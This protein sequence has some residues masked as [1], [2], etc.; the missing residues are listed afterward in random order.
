M[1]RRH[2]NAAIG[3][4]K[5]YTHPGRR[6]GMFRLSGAENDT[7]LDSHRTPRFGILERKMAHHRT[8]TQPHGTT[9]IRPDAV[10][11]G[12]RFHVSAFRCGKWHNPELS[13]TQL[14]LYKEG[15]FLPESHGITHILA[16]AAFTADGMCGYI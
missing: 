8:L 16:D 14:S 3:T 5:D 15:M 2:S 10:L 6:K 12:C 11:L 7:S 13:K 4:S 1:C 9:H